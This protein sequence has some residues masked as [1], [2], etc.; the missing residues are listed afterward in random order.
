[1]DPTIFDLSVNQASV[2][3]DANRSILPT[4][5]VMPD[6]RA[7][8]IIDRLTAPQLGRAYGLEVLLRRQSRTGLFG[9]I[10]YTLSRSERYRDGDWAPYDFDRPHLF[11]VVAGLP[12][13]PQ[14]GS[15]P[16]PAVP[17]RQ[18][19]HHDRRLQRRRTARATFVSTFASTSAPSGAAGCS[20]STST[21]PTSRSSPRR[22]SPAPSSAT[23]SHR[24]RAREVLIQ[25]PLPL[26][27]G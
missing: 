6:D 12:L 22:S 20:T 8:E 23:S 3:T 27:E 17:E 2:V 1:M 18:P 5:I 14:L 7:Q 26:G 11:N 21:S 16:A 13:P 4:N 15:R 24:R 9:W 19:H 25:S 10:S